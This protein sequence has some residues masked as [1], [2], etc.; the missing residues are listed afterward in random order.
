MCVQDLG[1]E[2][3]GAVLHA[4][5]LVQGEALLAH[6]PAGEGGKV[7]VSQAARPLGPE[8][9][10][11]AALDAVTAVPRSPQNPTQGPRTSFRRGTLYP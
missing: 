3:W 7:V 10:T 6:C 5:L 4:A 1:G 2:A 9:R 11:W 8:P